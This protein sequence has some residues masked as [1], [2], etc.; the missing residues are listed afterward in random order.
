MEKKVLSNDEIKKKQNKIIWTTRIVGVVLFLVGISIIFIT[1]FLRSRQIDEPINEN[2]VLFESSGDNFTMYDSDENIL[3]EEFIILKSI[4]DYNNFMSELDTWYQNCNDDFVDAT[5][6]NI[7]LSDEDKT[8]EID[9]YKTFNDQRYLNIKSLVNDANINEEKFNDKIFIVVE[10]ITSNMVLHEHNL[11]DICLDEDKLT[12]HFIK[13]SLGVVADRVSSLYFIELDK[14]YADK[15]I[16]INVSNVASGNVNV[17]YKPIIY[18][19]PEEEMNVNVKLN[20]EDR[21]LVSYPEYRNNWS[22]FA[23]ED[24]MLIDNKTGRELYSLYYEASNKLDFKVE[25]DG[26][27]V[28]K[29][30]IIPFLESKL[31]ILGLNYK[32]SEEFIIY[33]LPIL[34]KNNYNYIRFASMD[35]INENLSLDVDPKPESLIRVLMTFKGLDEKIEVREQKLDKVVRR[36]YSVVEWGA[37]IIE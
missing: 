35:E 23:K 12:I 16:F 22:V 20:F 3:D 2:L 18:I 25:E 29:D 5:N 14:E 17:S 30:E 13:D 21:L 32:E 31:E 8:K 34:M 6:N 11:N 36:G 28:G 24:G 9:D 33:W 37:T 15:D 10:D 7:Y 26:F 19:Y 1:A 4:D 27:I